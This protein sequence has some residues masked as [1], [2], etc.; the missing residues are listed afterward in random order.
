MENFKKEFKEDKILRLSIY[1]TLAIISYVTI[2]L[3]INP[4]ILAYTI[5]IAIGGLLIVLVW[6]L[7]Y[8]FLDEIKNDN[9][10]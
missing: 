5:L 2:V 6:G 4:M 3:L 8:A 10:F 1:I 9:I 7:I